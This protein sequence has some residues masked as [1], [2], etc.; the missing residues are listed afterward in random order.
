MLKGEKEHREEKK[1][2]VNT[3]D[4][5]ENESKNNRSL[6]RELKINNMRYRMKEK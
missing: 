4:Y 5:Q 2:T 3:I 1:K 6:S